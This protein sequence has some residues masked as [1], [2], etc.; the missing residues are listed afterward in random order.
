MGEEGLKWYTYAP[1]LIPSKISLIL[2][3]SWMKKSKILKEIQ[4]ENEGD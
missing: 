4:E 1:I 2:I 3:K